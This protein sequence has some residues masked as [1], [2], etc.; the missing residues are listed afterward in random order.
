MDI[1]DPYFILDYYRSLFEPEQC[2]SPIDNY[3]SRMICEFCDVEL[4]IDAKSYYNVCPN[5]CRG[6]PYCDYINEKKRFSPC[7]KRKWHMMTVI[8]KNSYRIN[9]YEIDKVMNLYK[10][11]DRLYF[12]MFPKK[13]MV[14]L[15]YVLQYI[16]CTPA[17]CNTSGSRG[18]L[19]K[20]EAHN[21]GCSE[22]DADFD[23]SS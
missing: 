18:L 19:L 11:L 10:E 1:S 14:Y 3:R 23:D 2:S 16:Q 12:K 15:P 22:L 8:R 13:N 9:G 17:I 21:G 5:C 20:R 7:Y 6:F 4:I